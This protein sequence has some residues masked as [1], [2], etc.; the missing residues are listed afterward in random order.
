MNLFYKLIIISAFI[1][2]G[3]SISAQI[4]IGTVSVGNGSNQIDMTITVNTNDSTVSFDLTGPSSRWFG[5][6][7]AAS[8]MNGGAYTILGNVN[9]GNPM[10]YNQVNHSN[11]TLQ[12]TQN[13]SNISSSTNGGQKAYTFTRAMNT[14]DANDFIFL[15]S[16][17]SIN[18]IWAYGSS[19]N[20]AKH[21]A[22]GTA[23]INLA[24]A[25][26]IPVT[27][28]PQITICEGDSAMIF[29]NYKTQAADYYDTLQ[30]SLG[31][32]SVLKINLSTI[33]IDTQVYVSNNTLNSA[34]A[35]ANS[36]QWYDCQT[37]QA[38]AGETNMTYSPTQNGSYKVEIVT[39]FCSR[40]SS[41]HSVNW[42]GIEEIIANKIKVS[43]NPVINNLLIDIP[44]FNKNFSIT[45]ISIEGRIL[46]EIN[47][48]SGLTTLD[49]S[50]LNSG[51][52]IYKIEAEGTI[53]KSNRFIKR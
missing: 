46:K 9:S 31:C 37:D 44:D 28:L 38:I 1:F 51:M 21:A 33:Q 43:P 13:L 22:K 17:S 39:S 16:T 32:D 6:G 25:C 23:S 11:P 27:V 8:N 29:G 4:N 19:T 40:M 18:L 10:E 5:F 3:N 12:T 20:L 30:T 47:I 36:Y 34:Y 35:F 14:N 50:L 24:S 7:F 53:L 41:C 52:Y 2:L 49:L 48:N 45:I 42:V 15:L 26:N